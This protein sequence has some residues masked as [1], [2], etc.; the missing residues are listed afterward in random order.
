MKIFYNPSFEGRAISGKNIPATLRFT[1]IEILLVTV[2]FAI[3]ASILLPVIKE[4]RAR[5]KFTRW[6]AYNRIWSNDPDCVINFNFQD[7]KGDMLKNTAIACN[8]LRYNET[9]YNG[10]LM[11]N[12]T[13]TTHNFKWVAGGRFGKWKKALQF[14]GTDTYVV[15]PTTESVNFTPWSSFTIS[16]WVK[17]DVVGKGDCP[18]SKSLWGTSTDA[19]AQYDLY[20]VT[21]C[22]KYGQ[23]S[24]DVDA[25]KT[26]ASWNSTDVDFNSKEWTHLVLRYR[27][28]SD[29]VAGQDVNCEIICFV[30]GKPLGDYIIT[31]TED[32]GRCSATDWENSLSVPCV[33]GGAGCYRKYWA[34]TTLKKDDTSL[35]NLLY[36]NPSFI[37]NGRMDEFMLFKRALTNEEIKGIYEMGKE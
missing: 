16:T 19:S 18:F 35:D 21:F 1:L 27:Y 29:K 4:A 3:L 15:I 25:F 13:G 31:Y 28:L 23:G 14:N 37:F 20:A 30:N 2:I 34:P 6:F 10:T 32:P 9:L 11:S 22:G 8:D 26:C 12:A 36:V 7:G 33:L 24:F 5:A 17:F